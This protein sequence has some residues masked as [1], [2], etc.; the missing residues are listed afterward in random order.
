MSV[1]FNRERSAGK[2]VKWTGSRLMVRNNSCDQCREELRTF[3]NVNCLVQEN[4]DEAL[5]TLFKSAT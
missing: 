2:Q 5:Q 1:V 4:N 3:L